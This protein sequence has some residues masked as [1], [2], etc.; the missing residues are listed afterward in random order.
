MVSDV[1]PLP[2]LTYRLLTT[3]AAPLA[4][5]LLARRRARGKEDPL[6][7]GERRGTPSIARP[8][9]RLVW[10]HAASV[11]ET[12]CVLPLISSMLQ[13]DQAL[14]ILLTTGTVTSAQLAG[15]R[16]PARALHQ[17]APIDVPSFID[18]FLAHWQ[19][20][21]AL[22][23]ESEIWPNMLTGVRRYAIPAVLLNGRMSPRSAGR[24]GQFAGSAK[25]VLAS[26]DLCLAQSEGD[27]QRLA[28]LG[29]R[30]VRH[31]GN[32]KFDTPAPAAD[33]EDL[34]ALRTAIAG[35]PVWLAASTH[36]GEEAIV[37][38]AHR[39]AADHLP[40]L[41]TIIAPRHPQRGDEIAQLLRGMNLTVAQRSQGAL[42]SNGHQIYIADTLGEMGLLYRTSAIAYIGNSLAASGGHNP[43]EPAKLAAAI[44]HG[45]NV[46]NFAEIYTALDENKAARCVSSAQDLA[47]QIV[48]LALSPQAGEEMARQAQIVIDQWTGAL[49]RTL[50]ALAP[51]LAGTEHARA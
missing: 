29:A 43:I 11:G 3:L 51:L 9:G 39:I 7:L 25:Q 45:P 22:F 6:R 15:G 17:F 38:Q 26:F 4:G 37:A 41:L 21:L 35:R 34:A 8:Q 36:P 2:I 1:L 23:V 42:P 47:T 12:L 24:W 32:L 19:P 20:D 46:G 50:E 10:V 5:L 27:A 44:L 40:D 49:E 28:A 30:N 18:R 48:Q 16:L 33:D 31:V 14:H 13:R